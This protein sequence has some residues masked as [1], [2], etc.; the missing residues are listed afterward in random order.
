MSEP[1]VRALTIRQPWADAIVHGGNDW[2]PK[3]IENRTRPF[4][5]KYH[6]ATIL[7]HAGLAVDRQAVLDGILPG[8][9]VRGA[10]IGTCRIIGSHLDAS[11][12]RPWGQPDAWHWELTDVEPLPQ[13]VPARGALGLWDPTGV[14][15]AALRQEP[16]LT[17]GDLRAGFWPGMTGGLC[18]RCYLLISRGDAERPDPGHIECVTAFDR[19]TSGEGA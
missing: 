19:D 15:L 2:G 5:P 16:Q 7:I 12:C 18:S 4:P 11:C 10:V 14:M 17:I 1:T 9:N 6:W 8:P 3:R 13:P